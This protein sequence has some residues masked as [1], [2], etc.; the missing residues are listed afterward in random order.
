MMGGESVG[1]EAIR[2]DERYTRANVRS[3]KQGRTVSLASNIGG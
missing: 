2:W 1:N 3:V